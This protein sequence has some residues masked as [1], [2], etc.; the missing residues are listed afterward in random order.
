MTNRIPI[1]LAFLALAVLVTAASAFAHAHVLPEETLA[2]EP[3][4]FTLSVPNEK[5][6]AST[7]KVVLTV[8]D[9]FDIEQF[10][11]AQGWT[12]ETAA[13]DGGEHAHVSSVTWTAAGDGDP[14]G[15]LFQFVAVPESAEDYT[16]DV[17][18]TYSDGSVVDWAG[19]EGSDTP[20]PVVEAKSSLDEG[21]SSTLAIVALV[22][23][24]VG[25]VLACVA[26]AI[27]GGRQVA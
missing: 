14:Q 18:Q 23:G 9:G 21:G 24:G 26:L 6:D 11:P 27:K 10:V 25:V 12:Q 7:T 4:L 15:G 20:A 22:V 1:T 17:E 19:E 3:Q 13:T 16:F 8:P 5:D 2:E